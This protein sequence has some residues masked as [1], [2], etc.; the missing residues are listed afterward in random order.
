[1]FCNVVYYISLLVMASCF[2][3]TTSSLLRYLIITYT[4]YPEYYATCTVCIS[5]TIMPGMKWIIVA[6][7]FS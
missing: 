2:V 5:L 7:L 6:M 4:A 3:I 1:M